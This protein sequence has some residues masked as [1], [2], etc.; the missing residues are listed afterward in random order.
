MDEDHLLA[1]FRYVALNPVKAGLARRAAD[2]RWSSA[3][4]H[5][6]EIKVTLTETPEK[7][8]TN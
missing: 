4:A 6:A 7:R 1:A 3:A 5:I 8:R 2:W